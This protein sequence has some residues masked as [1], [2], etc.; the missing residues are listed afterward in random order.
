[1]PFRRIPVFIIFF[2]AADWRLEE[3]SLEQRL[4]NVQCAFLTMKDHDF[5]ITRWEEGRCLGKTVMAVSVFS[6]SNH[7]F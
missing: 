2:K 7:T 6:S 4:V 3:T 5:C 1:M